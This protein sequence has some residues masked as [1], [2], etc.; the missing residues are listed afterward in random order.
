[1]PP[2]ARLRIKKSVFKQISS[3]NLVI[4]INPKYFSYSFPMRKSSEVLTANAENNIF[5]VNSMV[6]TRTLLTTSKLSNRKL[7]F[8]PSKNTL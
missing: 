1:M 2:E 5:P 6:A 3:K 8:K 7:V 4:P